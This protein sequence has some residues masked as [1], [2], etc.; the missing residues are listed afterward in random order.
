MF[1]VHDYNISKSEDDMVKGSTISENLIF[2]IMAALCMSA[3]SPTTTSHSYT[4][5]RDY[6]SDQVACVM[7][8]DECSWNVK[9]DAN[10]VGAELDLKYELFQME[11]AY[12]PIANPETIYS[13]CY[14]LEISLLTGVGYNCGFLNMIGGT[15]DTHLLATYI[16]TSFLDHDSSFEM[17]SLYPNIERAQ[18]TDEQNSIYYYP[19]YD[20]Y[21]DEKNGSF[22]LIGGTYAWEADFYASQNSLLNS[23][24]SSDI[25]ANMYTYDSSTTSDYVISQFIDYPTRKMGDGNTLNYYGIFNFTCSTMPEE[26][27]VHVYSDYLWGTESDWLMKTYEEDRTDNTF[28]LPS[29]S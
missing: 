18:T 21:S 3:A 6:T 9:N 27:K 25:G 13:L 4:M 14:K 29:V 7:A 22:G 19:C 23:D 24:S 11:H 12:T 5:D 10:N 2:P 15:S 28:S 20:S 26:F 16:V 1:N 17:E 8:S